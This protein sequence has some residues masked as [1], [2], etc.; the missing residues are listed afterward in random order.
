M[1]RQFGLHTFTVTALTKTS[2]TL[3]NANTAMAGVGTSFLTQLKAGD[4]VYAYETATQKYW[5]LWI[6]SVT[7]DTAAVLEQNFEGP[8]AA[9]YDC[10]V[11]RNSDA[12]VIDLPQRTGIT[13]PGL[14]S[15]PLFIDLST[16][17]MTH[18]KLYPSRAIRWCWIKDDTAS[19]RLAAATALLTAK[20]TDAYKAAGYAASLEITLEIE[21]MIEAGYKLYVI[22]NDG[23]AGTISWYGYFSEYK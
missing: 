17:K 15:A 13:L 6:K 14:G 9:T 2:I 3:T 10:Y 7:N 11:I 19:N 5:G 1:S 8:T 16:F 12:S 4:I 22:S 21:Q 23:T 20:Y 18:L